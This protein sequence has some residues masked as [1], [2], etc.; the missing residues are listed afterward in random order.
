MWIFQRICFL[1]IYH[2]WK[3][4]PF[5]VDQDLKTLKIFEHLRFSCLLV[6]TANV[7]SIFIHFSWWRGNYMSNPLWSVQY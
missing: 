7:A 2:F 3:S 1:G 5:K 6:T 4:G